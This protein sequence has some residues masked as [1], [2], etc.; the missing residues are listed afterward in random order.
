MVV[1]ISLQPILACT[2]AEVVIATLRG[3]GNVLVRVDTSG[4]VLELALF[5]DEYWAR[6]RCE[7][8]AHVNLEAEFGCLAGQAVFLSLD[9][10]AEC[11]NWRC[12]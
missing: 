4:R 9:Q 11:C 2:C 8:A 3:D 12:S 7:G 10:M 6:E 1:G 5:L